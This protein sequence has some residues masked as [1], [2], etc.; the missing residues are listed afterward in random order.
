MPHVYSLEHLTA[1][2]CTPPELVYVAA[3][4]GYDQVGLRTIPL[5]LPDEP[6]CEVAHD[7]VLLRR[8]RDALAATGLSISDIELVRILP[9]MDP[10]SYE[11]AFA[12]G[13]EL[14]ATDVTASIWTSEA[15]YARDMF[16]EVC[17]VA[18]PYGLRLN[19]EF[20]AIA[21]VRNLSQAAWILNSVDATN[22]GML[23]DMYHLHRAR[24]DLSELDGLPADW[25]S[26]CQ[27]CDAPA[28]IPDSWEDIRQEVRE[29]RLYLGEGAI[30]VSSILAR[31]PDMV[32]ALEIPNRTRLE[33][34]GPEAYAR[35]CLRTARRYFGDG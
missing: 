26:V 33:E 22:V 24:V 14:G 1:L 13:A 12:A 15:A 4:A 7:P 16:D 2:R 3:R 25:F 23:L 21:N 20:V 32:Y 6:E 35:Q 17:A 18:K 31:L 28:G 8:T 9:S 34:L 27:L 10:Q 11:P 5:G 29:R 30:D 19:L